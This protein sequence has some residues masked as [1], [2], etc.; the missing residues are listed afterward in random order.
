MLLMLSFLVSIA[1]SASMAFAQSIAPQGDSTFD[2][3]AEL[4]RV[5]LKTSLQDTPAPG[6]V[7]H[8]HAGEDPSQA[9]SRASCGDTVELEAGATFRQLQLPQKNC[10]DSHWI[11]VRTSAPD[12]KLP[13]EGTRLT[14]CYAGIASLAGRP[15]FSCDSAEN[16]LSKIEFS[17]KG[18]SGPVTIAPGANHYR[19]IGLEV[20]RAESP[21]TIHNLIS[22]D[23]GPADHLVFDR[24]WIHGTA[25]SETVRGLML[26]H[27]RDVGV[28]D[29]YFSDFHCVAKS[30]TCTD[31]QAI[32]GGLG[33]DPMGPYKIENNFLEAAA[34]CILFGG[35]GANATPSDIEIRRNHLFKPLIWMRGV[36]GFVGGTDGNAFIVKNL[37]ELKN[38][39][40]VLVEDNIMEN[41]WG[42]FSQVGFAILLTPKNPGS[43]PGCKVR[44]V[45]IRYDRIAHCGAAMSIANGTSDNGLAAQEGGQYS[46]HDL[47]FDDMKYEECQGCNGDM[48][49]I[50]TS[51]RSPSGLL[52][53]A[54]SIR[55]VTLATNR[56]RAGWIIA[57]P[58]G[59]KNMT[60]QDNIVDAGTIGHANAGGGAAQ[61]Y[62][63]QGI[64][65]GVLDRCWSSYY[66]DHNIIMNANP[67]HNW[68][69]G[70]WPIGGGEKVGFVNWRGGVAG[71]YH[72]TA[73]SKFKGKAS[74]GKDPGADMDLVNS[75]TSGVQ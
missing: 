30:G 75:R 11:I 59:Q 52:L 15:S 67:A 71:D 51:M 3:P 36:H 7:V 19:L 38:A 69:S 27:M 64:I 24:M 9:L 26:S 56:A 46:I 10:D 20:T 43:C 41:T 57:G 1:L 53:H 68:P 18:G 62:F 72:L 37:F 21:G 54:V 5:H 28:V 73:Q 44:D 4:P 12:S 74:D 39:E 63:R 70:N 31:S 45:T 66:F 40:R 35:G 50:T 65:K 33:D 22:P 6:K 17:S 13:P 8:V 23:N 25:Q 2:G 49:Q 32:A 61:C 47:V 60:F 14:P 42:G 58:I 34:E 16:V 48:F 55:H 29:S